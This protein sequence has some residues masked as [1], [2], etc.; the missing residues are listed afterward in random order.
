MALLTNMP[1]ELFR[2]ILQLEDINFD[3]VQNQL[4]GKNTPVDLLEYN[5]RDV[6]MDGLDLHRPIAK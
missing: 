6:V 4:E 1:V 2:M 3:A 5:V